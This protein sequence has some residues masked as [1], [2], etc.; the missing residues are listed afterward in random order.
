MYVFLGIEWEKINLKTKFSNKTIGKVKI[1]AFLLKIS[2][3]LSW[4]LSKRATKTITSA[5]KMTF[6]G[7][8]TDYV[9]DSETGKV[10][11]CEVR[12][13]RYSPPIK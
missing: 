13:E 7:G 11:R 8:I 6:F 2:V 9:G 5:N 1:P 4:T 3:F 12:R 10:V